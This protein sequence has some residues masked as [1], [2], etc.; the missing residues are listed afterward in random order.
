MSETEAKFLLEGPEQTALLIDSLEQTSDKLKVQKT[1]RR[2][3][4]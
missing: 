2:P 1:A 4:C 3:D